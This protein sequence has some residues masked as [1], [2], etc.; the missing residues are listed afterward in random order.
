VLKRRNELKFI[1]A[2]IVLIEK[3]NQ[4]SFI[5]ESLCPTLNIF[6]T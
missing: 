3:F 4:R 5:D 2:S 1:L 6:V